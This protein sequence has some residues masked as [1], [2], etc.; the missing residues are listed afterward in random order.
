VS[1]ELTDVLVAGYRSVDS[2]KRDFDALLDRVNA[3]QGQTGT[4]RTLRAARS[5]G[6]CGRMTRLTW[7]ENAL[8]AS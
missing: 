8:E 3:K 2:A 5:R 7:A 6:G 4:A 1:D